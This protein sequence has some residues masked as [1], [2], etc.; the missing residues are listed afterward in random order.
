M[1]PQLSSREREVLMWA[2]EGMTALETASIL[3]VSASAVN[4]YAQRAMSKLQ[5]RTKTQAVAIAMRIDGFPH[6]NA[7]VTNA[8]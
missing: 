2:A 4:L 8:A 5:A 3:K 7:S 6:V 1:S